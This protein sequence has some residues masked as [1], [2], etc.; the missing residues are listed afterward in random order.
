MLQKHR[1]MITNKETLSKKKKNQSKNYCDKDS[2]ERF[3]KDI[4]SHCRTIT[5]SV[6]GKEINQKLS[7]NEIRFGTNGSLSIRYNNGNPH[8][9]NFETGEHGD[10]IELVKTHLGCT[11]IEAIQHIENITGINCERE[12]YS[13]NNYNYQDRE[14]IESVERRLSKNLAQKPIEAPV[15]SDENKIKKAQKEYHNAELLEPDHC[16]IYEYKP[17]KKQDPLA[18][19]LAA[20]EYLFDMRSLHNLPIIRDYIK[21][22]GICYKKGT[23]LFPLRNDN[24]KITA[25]QQ[26]IIKDKQRK[27]DDG[28]VVW[29]KK[30]N[31]R[32]KRVGRD[33]SSF[34]KEKKNHGIM[35]G[36]AFRLPEVNESN[37]LYITEGVEDALTIWGVTGCKTWATCGSLNMIKNLKLPKDKEIIF[38]KDKDDKESPSAKQFPKIIERL[39]KEGIYPKYI[40]VPEKEELAKIFNDQGDISRIAKSQ[41]KDFNDLLQIVKGRKLIERWDQIYEE[42]ECKPE[43]FID[44]RRKYLDVE[45]ATKTLNE[46][47]ER[48]FQ[49]SL[50]SNKN[51]P[52]IGMKA[53]A[54]IGKT[55]AVVS[56]AI[57]VYKEG[58]LT[59][60]MLKKR[61]KIEFY[62]P[63]TKLAE[64]V[65]QRLN[66][67]AKEQNIQITT[68][69]MRGRT[70]EYVEMCK[71]KDEVELVNKAGLSVNER[72]CI[73]KDKNGNE[74]KCPFFDQCKYQK[75]FNE[76]YDIIIL[77]H[78]YLIRRPEKLAKPDLRI[79]DEKFYHKLLKS[80]EIPISLFTKITE[81]NLQERSGEIGHK[82]WNDN[83][84]IIK[85][86]N[87]IYEGIVKDKDNLK[88]HLKSEGY[89]GESLKKTANQLIENYKTADFP[90]NAPLE[91]I[92]E[93]LSNN[94]YKGNAFKISRTIKQIAKEIDYPEDR[95]FKIKHQKITVSW[96]QDISLKR[97]PTLIIDA[98]YDHEII[99]KI[100]PSIQYKEINVRKNTKTEQ[101]INR[102]CSQLALIADNKG[103]KSKKTA[104]N[105]R[106]K[107][108]KILNKEADIKK[109]EK[110]LLVTYKKAVELIQEENNLKENIETAHFG[111]LR[112]ID[113]FKDCSTVFIAGRNL[114]TISSIQLQ[115]MALHG[116]DDEP[117]EL[118]DETKDWPR[119][120]ENILTKDGKNIVVEK[121]PY[122]PDKRVNRLLRQIMHNETEQAIDRIRAVHSKEVKKVVI[123]S[124]IA[125]DS[126]IDEIKE[127]EEISVSKLDQHTIENNF[128]VPI[129]NAHEIS[130][131]IWS[132]KRNKNEYIKRIFDKQLKEERRG[133]IE[134]Q[135][136][137]DNNSSRFEVVS[138]RL[139]GQRG[140]S[141]TIIMPKKF[142]NRYKETIQGKL[143]INTEIIDLQPVKL[144]QKNNSH[145]KYIRMIYYIEQLYKEYTQTEISVCK[146]TPHY[147][148]N[149]LTKDIPFDGKISAIGLLGKLLKDPPEI[150]TPL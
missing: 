125:L 140:S 69:I 16:D 92:K 70:N 5:E 126:P 33:T 149:N 34:T 107:I 108:A 76:E 61:P 42:K 110:I 115:A 84:N 35:K 40:E 71:R 130:P 2:I 23:V 31:Y 14:D 123:L 9:Q 47:I 98:D 63:N 80:Q 112:G 45:E 26:I 102:S 74:S 13:P 32:K 41:I 58:S 15:E 51:I 19:Y 18:D 29:K 77:P 122:H 124:N 75:Q 28:K 105:N 111:N 147:Y 4:A 106:E 87:D 56:Q 53:S 91:K 137:Y 104:K 72:L 7:K 81:S 20:A 100:L 89:D 17:E 150:Q 44:K 65:Q 54:G 43:W 50:S 57:E 82:D 83:G 145:H 52:F 146:D 67:K 22:S 134:L 12:S 120:D 139:K 1:D 49:D 90:I 10:L 93:C 144:D 64:E 94:P 24:N 128:I 121:Q 6:I 21:K 73:R 132:N 141:S 127:W 119:R 148:Q 68:K 3:K 131:H 95:Y 117:L 36:S 133:N 114:P 88:Q 138:Y 116:E 101:I 79:I 78:D 38:C 66:K 55:E 37:K 99:K 86:C 46:N 11:F 143:N 118:I 62:V 109:S 60:N 96:L 48:F 135:E 113:K 142:R 25:Y 39:Y 59:N 85:L 129:S 103:D 136:L 27:L 30:N 97:T 8:F